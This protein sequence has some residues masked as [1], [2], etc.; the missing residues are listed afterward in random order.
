[1]PLERNIRLQAAVADLLARE[2]DFLDRR[3]WDDWLDLFVEDAIYWVP[4]WRNEDETVSDPSGGVSLI[5]C[6]GKERLRE[7]IQRLRSGHSPAS[8]PL[9]RTLHMQSHL[10]VSRAEDGHVRAATSW[11]CHQYS[12]KNDVTV[13]L[14]GRCEYNLGHE[15]SLAIL[16]KKVTLLNDVITAPLDIYSI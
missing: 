8:V 1:M 14:F 9:P 6:E 2:A 4:A 15:G 3:Q 16:F 10:I 13:T 11:T 5:Y 7:R 12:P